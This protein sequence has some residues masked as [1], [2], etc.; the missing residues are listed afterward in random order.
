M[1]DKRRSLAVYS[2]SSSV[3]REFV[4]SISNVHIS[5]LVTGISVKM[6]MRGSLSPFQ[7]TSRFDNT[8]ITFGDMRE[9]IEWCIFY[10]PCSVI[11]SIIW[12]L[13]SFSVQ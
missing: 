1:Q 2:L 9:N 12:T 10:S 5:A 3:I 13:L 8:T 4:P 7:I 6:A 11:G